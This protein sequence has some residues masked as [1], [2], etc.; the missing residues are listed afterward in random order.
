MLE[1]S[2]LYFIAN[3]IRQKGRNRKRVIL[4]GTGTRT[5]KFIDTVN[6]NFSWGLDIIGLLTG[7]KEKVG[8]LIYGVKVLDIYSNI[9]SILKEFNPEE[10]IIT[11]STKRFDKLREVLEICERE[12]VKIRL[13]SDFFG[14]LVK[15]VQVDKVFGLNIITIDM[16]K[17][18]E[19]KL[20]IKR[21]ID[22]VVSSLTLILFLPF[23]AIAA[24]GILISDGLPILYNWNV[25]GKDKKQFRSWKFRTMVKNADQLKNKLAVKN[26][27][28]GPVFKIKNDPRIIPFGKFL[29]K[30]SIDETPQLFSVLKGNMSL[31]GPR[32]AGPHELN[33]YQ[34]WHRRKLSVRPGITCLWQVKGRNKINNFDDWV[35]LDLEYIDNWNLLLDIKILLKTIPA[36]LFGKGAS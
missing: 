35:K 1:K 16:I 33:N 27:M 30:W 31:V 10:I 19:T 25:I 28:N 7:D 4:I 32:P 18:S 15:N 17:H 14:K 13:N 11:L 29:R 3:Y 24:I 5:K 23:M 34:S 2:L 36:V 22:I 9:E 6:K 12:G 8:R 26:E 20:L 21:I